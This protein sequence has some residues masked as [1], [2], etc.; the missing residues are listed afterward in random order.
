ML[1]FHGFARYPDGSQ[2]EGDGLVERP[3]E[4][5]K[6]GGRIHYLEPDT[7]GQPVRGYFHVC[8]SDFAEETEC[9]S[10]REVKLE[11]NIGSRGILFMFFQGRG[12]DMDSVFRNV[13]DEHPEVLISGKTFSL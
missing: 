1:L 6:P 7:V 2:A 3:H 12:N 9:L 11:I 5:D 4:L 8:P 10:G 13:L